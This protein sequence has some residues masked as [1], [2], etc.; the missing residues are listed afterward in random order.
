MREGK[1]IKVPSMRSKPSTVPSSAARISLFVI[2]K[3]LPLRP[4]ERRDSQ[5]VREGTRRM[6]ELIDDLLRF[7]RLSRSALNKREVANV[8]T[9]L[10]VLKDNCRL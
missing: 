7:S 8:A 10:L 1:S 9:H 3:L 6:G 2:K 4:E 5:T